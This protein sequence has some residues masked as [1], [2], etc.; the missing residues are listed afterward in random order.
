MK[1]LLSLLCLALTSCATVEIKNEPSGK[2]A[3]IPYYKTGTCDWCG[4]KASE[5]EP[6]IFIE[7]YASDPRFSHKILHGRCLALY[8][9][10]TN[11]HSR[12]LIIPTKE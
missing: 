3:A 5:N 7:N 11:P 2:L 12:Y 1:I 8:L 4:K 6:L 10:A 9:D